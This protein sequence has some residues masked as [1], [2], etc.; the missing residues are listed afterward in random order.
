MGRRVS[1]DSSGIKHFPQHGVTVQRK[2][3]RLYV[4]CRK[5]YLDVRGIRHEHRVYIGHVINNTFYTNEESFKR[6]ILQ[7]A[8]PGQADIQLLP[9][10]MAVLENGPE[11]DP[12]IGKLS[13]H[14]IHLL[15]QFYL[16]NPEFIRKSPF[17]VR[18]LAQVLQELA[19]NPDHI[20]WQQALQS[21]TEG[22]RRRGAKSRSG[23][24]TP[25]SG[26]ATP[27]TGTA[28]PTAAPAAT[29]IP[30]AA[31]APADTASTANTS[32]AS[33]SSASTA[34][35][36]APRRYGAASALGSVPANDEVSTHEGVLSC[37]AAPQSMT[38]ARDKS[39]TAL[40][41]LTGSSVR[42]S[43]GLGKD[44]RPRK[45][46][47]PSAEDIFLEAQIDIFNFT[48]TDE[49][50]AWLNIDPYKRGLGLTRSDLKAQGL[51]PRALEGVGAS[52]APSAAGDAA[53][54]A[55]LDA[56]EFM[57]AAQAAKSAAKTAKSVELNVPPDLMAAGAV[58][59]Q[60][61]I[62]TSSDFPSGHDGAQLE[63]GLELTHVAR[64]GAKAIAPSSEGGGPLTL[65]L[66]L[67]RPHKN[68]SMVALDEQSP[69][70]Y[71]ARYRVYESDC[72]RWGFLTEQSLFAF[73]QHARHD[74]FLEQLSCDLDQY[75]RTRNLY[76]MQVESQERFFSPI[77]I[78]TE[79]VVSVIP[80]KMQRTS[81]LFYQE[82]RDRSGMLRFAQKSRHACCE[83]SQGLQVN[84]PD[85]IFDSI[86]P[87]V[88]TGP[89]QESL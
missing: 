43:S 13:L 41:S 52:K 61:T 3:D 89:V 69:A 84:V 8:A 5:F 1:F 45:N 48:T 49:F 42:G 72:N 55:R 40:G 54:S 56:D 36:S 67:T 12:G 28:T 71:M 62:V 74:F 10:A 16:H 76:F 25:S 64:H 29:A 87:F 47:V 18:A 9:N 50:K 85:S 33:T 46:A 59:S 73:C 70:Y 75:L 37:S 19:L 60:R 68:G 32:H 31:A 78:G 38:G 17:T 6:R 65:S 44:S 20:L 79:I 58:R 24:A 63:T 57:R 53:T 77:A 81:I 51:N 80:L 15:Q 7:Q 66:W 14:Q 86:A 39:L 34:G 82:V 23:T 21:L 30:A 26:N 4:M 35:A 83:Y 88:P 27:S 22:P 2:P 11:F